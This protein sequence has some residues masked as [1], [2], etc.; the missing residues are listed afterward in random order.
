MK[1]ALYFGCLLL[2]CFYSCKKEKDAVPNVPPPAASTPDYFPITTGCYWIYERFHMDTNGV[3]TIVAIDSSYVSGDT[4][5]NGNTFAVFVGTYYDPNAIYC[6]RDS[7]GYIID[8]HGI[9]YFSSTNFTDTLRTGNTPGYYTSFY[10]MIPAGPVTVPAGIFS[11]YG[12]MGTVN[13]TLPGY[14]WDNPRYTYCFYADGIGLVRETNFFLMNPNYD[15]RRLV[16]YN[17]Q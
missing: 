7:S 2:L 6:R 12:Y 4:L 16:R 14:L 9:V 13:I 1:N 10:K 11:A 17:I 15:G 3:E 8:Q 5:I